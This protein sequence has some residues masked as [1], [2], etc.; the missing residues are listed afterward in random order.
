[1]VYGGWYDSDANISVAIPTPAGATRVD[2]IVLRKDWAGQTIRLTRIAGVEGAGAPALGAGT[3][4]YTQSA[5]VTWDVPLYQVSITTGGV[6][7][8]VDDREGLAGSIGGTPTQIDIGDL[9]D[10]GT[11][12][13]PADKDH[14]HA[15][16][17]ASSV[18]NVAFDGVQVV[19]TDPR[20]SSQDHAHK[21]PKI[22]RI[23]KDADTSY[24]STSGTDDPD[25]LFTVAVNERYIISGTIFYTGGASGP[26]LRTLITLPVGATIE[27]EV[28]G[29]KSSAPD[30]ATLQNVSTDWTVGAVAD[31]T[32][33]GYHFSGTLNIGA[34]A[35]VPVQFQFAKATATVDPI[36]V[37]DNS[38][39]LA[40][41]VGI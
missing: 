16:P 4:P 38:N 27:L 9:T 12:G 7:T 5:G 22:H 23:Y 33:R 39:I 41:Q 24:S 36:V 17:G 34:S 1:M 32:P 30:D 40:I 3:P 20:P 37:R 2:R 25:L 21:S 31:A 19:G 35:A 13:I 8:T 15:F 28:V 18:A 11:S 14:Q 6:I 10:A 26:A 29:P